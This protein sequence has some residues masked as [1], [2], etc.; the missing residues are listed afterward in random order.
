[1]IY[2]NS[3]SE[4]GLR[5]GDFSGRDQFSVISE[6]ILAIFSL[7][8][9]ILEVSLPEVCAVLGVSGQDGIAGVNPVSRGGYQA[10]LYSSTGPGLK[11]IGRE[12]GR[13][14]YVARNFGIFSQFQLYQQEY[15]VST[16]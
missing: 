13:F 12:P 14:N 15:A 6:Q 5:T 10:H 1:M 8:F 9:L 16:S 2:D 4:F 11:F 3:L 7:H